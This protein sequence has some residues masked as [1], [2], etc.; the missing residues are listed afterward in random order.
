MVRFTKRWGVL[1][2]MKKAG[3]ETPTGFCYLSNRNAIN[4]PGFEPGILL[5]WKLRQ[6]RVRGWETGVCSGGWIPTINVVPN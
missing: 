5:H 6:W 1:G 3:K 4:I 2:E